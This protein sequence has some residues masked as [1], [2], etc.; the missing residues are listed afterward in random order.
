MRPID[1]TLLGMRGS[2]PGIAWPP[3]HGGTRASLASLLFQLDATQ[4]LAPEEIERGQF[5]QL[6]LLAVHLDAHSPHFRARLK[7]AGLQPSELAS[8]EA[9]RALA[10]LTRRD[11]QAAGRSL[12]CTAVPKGHFPLG[13]VKTSGST[14]EPVVVKRSAVT[15]LF[16]MALTLR[17][18]FW[19]CR[20]F[21][22]GLSAI[23]ATVPEHRESEGWGA[24]FDLLYATG[25]GQHI[26]ITTPIAQQVGLLKS[27][28]PG[29]LLIYPSNLA[30]LANAFG[31]AGERLDGLSHIRTIGETLS[32]AVRALAETIFGAPVED[33]YSSQEL[34]SIAIQCPESGLYHAMAESLIVEVLDDRG[35]PCAVGGVGR[36]VVTDLHNFATPLVRYDLGDYAEVAGRCP[37]GRGLPALKR[38]LGRERNLILMPDGTRHWPLVGFAEFRSVAPVVQYQMIQEA[39]EGIEVRLVTERALTHGE[40]DALRRVIQAAL[41]HPFALRFSYYAD[42]IPSGPNGKFEEFVCRVDQEPTV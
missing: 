5:A 18:H 7:A 17:D 4:W 2:V 19:H 14:G 40:E 34:G 33:V 12:F 27:F 36:L 1:R 26:P 8:P 38:V 3:L 37:C 11:L 35:A 10:P 42:R 24:P 41:G 39:R 23:R 30:A 28:R 6:K 13:E 31:Q 22:L 21:T 25:R 15:H 9:L 16:W 32:P 29:L 20:N